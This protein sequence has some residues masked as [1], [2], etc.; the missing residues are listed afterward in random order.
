M[1][2]TQYSSSSNISHP[3]EFL[4]WYL[5]YIRYIQGDPQRYSH[6]AGTCAGPHNNSSLNWIFFS[7]LYEIQGV[8]IKII[9][10]SL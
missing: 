9:T 1:L 4:F 6:S 5:P 8:Q 10:L 3:I 7:W 2:L